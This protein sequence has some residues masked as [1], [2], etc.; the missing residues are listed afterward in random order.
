MS[1]SGRN[2]KLGIAVLLILTLSV[3]MVSAAAPVAAFTCLP[4]NGAIPFDTTCTDASINVPTAWTWYVR[5]SSGLYTVTPATPDWEPII[6][7]SVYGP[8]S[9]NLTVTNLDGDS[10][11]NRSNYVTGWNTTIAGFTASTASGVKPLAVSFT[12]TTLYTPTT[13]AWTFGDGATSAAQNPSHTFTSEGTYT[14]V[15]TATNFA[16]SSAASTS[17]TVWSVSNAQV[18]AG[19]TTGVSQIVTALGLIGIG[20]VIVGIATLVY[21]LISIG[22]SNKSLAPFLVGAILSITIGAVLLVMAYILVD[23]VVP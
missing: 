19:L 21:L 2:L 10:W 13:W 20:L 23:A 16:G 14:I 17:I 15:L 12:D 8:Y 4:L 1:H 9:V 6:N 5:N 22:G 11:L 7:L 3:Q 18:S